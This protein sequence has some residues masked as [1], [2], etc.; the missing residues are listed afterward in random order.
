MNCSKFKVKSFISMVIQTKKS[1]SGLTFPKNQRRKNS[2]FRQKRHRSKSRLRLTSYHTRASLRISSK[3]SEMLMVYLSLT[4]NKKTSFIFITLRTQTPKTWSPFWSGSK[5][6]HQAMMNLNPQLRRQ[7]LKRQ[8][9]RN[10]EISEKKK[11]YT[12]IYK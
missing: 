6:Q 3:L 5:I 8:M 10:E 1:L 7:Q 9:M 11:I 2:K 12:K 4:K